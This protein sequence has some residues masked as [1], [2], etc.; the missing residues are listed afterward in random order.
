MFEMKY[1]IR[2][3]YLTKGSKKRPGNR[4]TPQFVVAHDTGNPGSTANGNVSYYTNVQ[5]ELSASAHLFVDDKEII[6]C[7]PALTSNPERAYHVVYNTPKDN[8]LFGDDANDIA[9]GVELCFGGKVNNEEAYKRYVWVIAYICYKFDMDP[10]KDIVS[11][12]ILDPGR[13]IDPDNGLSKM[14]KTYAQLKRDI[15]AEYNACI[16]G[17]VIKA[18]ALTVDKASKTHTVKAGDTLW[19]IA[20]KYAVDL[21]VLNDLNP[22][23]KASALK[24]GQVLFLAKA[25]AAAKPA[26]PFPGLLKLGSRGRYV[27]MVQKKLGAVPDEIFGKNTDRVVRNFQAKNKLDIDGKV[28][29]STW[30]AL[31]G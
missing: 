9:I 26:V 7:V 15:V 18:A 23:L 21:Q 17:E 30:K 2:K 4:I 5:N 29:P 16:G 20:N 3:K 19:A 27:A 10:S 13:K 22:G 6:E 24:I 31:F 8:L 14:G 12:K 28:G 1:P 11:H 25:A